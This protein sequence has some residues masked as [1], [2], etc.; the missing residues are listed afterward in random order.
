[1]CLQEINAELEDR[2]RELEDD[3][4][5]SHL[6]RTVAEVRRAAAWRL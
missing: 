2:M 1:M 6:Q 5:T 3:F 4:E